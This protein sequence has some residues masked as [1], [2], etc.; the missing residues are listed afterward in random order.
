MEDKKF[1]KISE[2]I[3]L[4]DMLNVYCDN[5]INNFFIPSGYDFLKKECDSFLAD[6]PNYDHNIFIMT[7]FEKGHRVS[8]EIDIELREVLRGHK[9]NP[10]RADDKMYLKDRNLWN[11]VCVYMICCKFGIAILEDRVKHELNPNVT[12]EYGFMRAL[13]K[14]VL[15]LTDKGFRNL[16]ADIFGTL[17]EDFDIIDIRGTIKDPVEKW[18]KELDINLVKLITTDDVTKNIKTI[19]K[20]EDLNERSEEMIMN[21]KLIEGILNQTFNIMHGNYSADIILGCQP[22]DTNGAR[23]NMIMIL[24]GIIAIKDGESNVLEIKSEKEGNY[25]DITKETIYEHTFLISY[26]NTWYCFYKCFW[27]KQ[28]KEDSY[29]KEIREFIDDNNTKIHYE[30]IDNDVIAMYLKRYLTNIQTNYL[31]F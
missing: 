28:N 21:L 1:R 22:K 2:V 31:R 15:L 24:S 12:L 20:N 3:K 13:N 25:K 8:E 18:L 7:S 5:K 26:S 27:S 6:H 23:K 10:V 19:V 4:E 14:Q 16:R 29:L 30:L 11:N 9:L 17:R